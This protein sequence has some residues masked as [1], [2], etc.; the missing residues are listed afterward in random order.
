MRERNGK[1]GLKGEKKTILCLEEM[2]FYQKLSFQMLTRMVSRVCTPKLKMA[3]S[4]A[5]MNRTGK[6][7]K[8]LGRNKNE[9]S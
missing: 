6:Q 8:K 1:Q 5:N 9:T 2:A 4:V 7:T 3:T